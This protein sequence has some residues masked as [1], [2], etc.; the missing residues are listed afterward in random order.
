MLSA[1]WP[2]RDSPMVAPFIGP[3]VRGVVHK[4]VDVR[5]SIG[6]P[7]IGV[8]HIPFGQEHLDL[9]L[10]ILSVSGKGHHVVKIAGVHDQNEVVLLEIL[11]LDLP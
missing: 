6:A 9:A 5:E 2:W 3:S 8:R 1:A 4:L 11:F 7:V 10:P